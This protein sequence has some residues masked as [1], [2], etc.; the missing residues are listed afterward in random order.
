M[1]SHRGGRASVRAAS[2]IRDRRHHSKSEQRQISRPLSTVSTP[3]TNQGATLSLCIIRSVGN[4]DHQTKVYKLSKDGTSRLKFASAKSRSKHASADVYRTSDKRV[5]SSSTAVREKR[6]HDAAESIT[7]RKRTRNKRGGEDGE[8]VRY[9]QRENDSEGLGIGRTAVIVSSKSKLA[10]KAKHHQEE[11]TRNTHELDEDAEEEHS[12]LLTGGTLFFTELEVASQRN[13]SQVFGKLVRELRPL[14]KSLAELLHHSEH[15]VGTLYA[16][17]LSPRGSDG[18]ATPLRRKDE[19][20][21]SYLKHLKEKVPDGYVVHVAT[22]DVLHLLG[23]L[24]RELRH[25]VY[26]Y[27]N[28]RLLPRIVGDLL[29]PPTYTVDSESS[30]KR[31]NVVPLDVSH[32]ETAFR[33]MSYLFKYSS[34][35]LI[36]NYQ[37][38]QIEPPAKQAGDADILRQYY[39]MTICHKRDI[40]RRLACESYAPIL[41]KCTDKGLKRHL[42][43][44]VKALASSLAAA[45]DGD[46]TQTAKRARDD[47][48]DGVSSLLFEVARGAPGSIHSKKGRIVLKAL[49]ECLLAGL[50]SAKSEN[51]VIELRKAEAIY[52]VASAVLYKLRG[53]VVRGSREGPVAAFDDVFACI[54]RALEEAIVAVKES[55]DSGFILGHIIDLERETIEFQDGRLVSDVDGIVGSL[56]EFLSE[57]VYPNASKDLQ[58][59]GLRYLCAAWKSNP[60]HPSFALRIG[61]YF[62]SVL[63]PS[64]DNSLGPALFLSKNLLPHLPKKIASRYLIPALMNAVA[65]QGRSDESLVLL[66][67][68]ATTVW[69]KE[70]VVDTTSIDLDDQAADKFFTSEGAEFCPDFRSELLRPLFDLCL[71]LGTPSD[72]STSEEKEDP[73]GKIGYVAR[74]MPFLVS[75]GCSRGDD[76]S[77]GENSSNELLG[78][79]FHWFASISKDLESVVDEETR[80][81]QAI[82]LEA[83][84]KSAIECHRRLSSSVVSSIE[85]TLSKMRN[86][87]NNLLFSHPK[88]A[89]VVRGVAAVTRALSILDP[90]TTLNDRANETF[91]ILVSNL[92]DSNHFL[93]LHTLAI[94]ESFPARPFVTDHADLDLTDDLDEEPS[95]R[96]NQPHSQDDEKVTDDRSGPAFSGSCEIISMLS[97]LEKTP[98]VLTN[99]RR[100]TSSLSRVEVFSRTGRLPI[101]YAEAVVCH[102]LGLLHVKFAP[103]WAAAV[104]VIVAISTAQESPA[105]P[106]INQ[107]LEQSMS[108]S[109]FAN[110]EIDDM[111]TD[112]CGTHYTASISRHYALCNSWESSEGRPVDIFSSELVERNSQVRGCILQLLNSGLL[113]HVIVSSDFSV[114]IDGRTDNFREYMVYLRECTEPDGHKVESDRPPIPRIPT[115]SILCLPS[116][117]TRFEGAQHCC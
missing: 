23:V 88:S 31:S 24:A 89:W 20:W 38:D 43:R 62:P 40:V 64:D 27:L 8:E 73:L 19:E 60:T 30:E 3:G 76:D 75:L 80:I 21:K 53:H 91:E 37:P 12:S 35:R 29:N 9:L 59:K 6:V 25:E 84:S 39:G 104:K 16:Y 36:D 63:S 54:H 83:F 15:I 107:A 98:I 33:S 17:L 51:D 85:S 106:Y 42:H 78:R 28:T 109:S 2:T 94:L 50:R 67:T 117:R 70:G 115:G 87:A 48:I 97:D 93:R 71:E 112:D 92:A 79:A 110:D 46:S 52:E 111:T 69:R 10:A 13:G 114:L 65:S 14:C 90:G 116:R 44:T 86:C 11:D 5:S 26:P 22:N 101:V 102:M 49:S 4:M 103:I 66:H 105:W 55:S 95:Q 74:C 82:L 7:S 99:E 56:Q 45:M 100:I 81:T 77:G 72:L 47:A 68:V 57:A 1:G 113:F 61:K 96:P 108:R 58:D 41:R 32:I 18:Q 34:N